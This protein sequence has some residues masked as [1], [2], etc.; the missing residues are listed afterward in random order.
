MAV[1]RV[2]TVPED[3]FGEPREHLRRTIQALNAL[4]NGQGNNHF[5]VT[6]RP[7]ETETTVPMRSATIGSTVQI[8]PMS[9]SAAIEVGF[10]GEAIQGAVVIHHGSDPGQ[11][12]VFGV[13]ISG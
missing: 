6:L 2:K 12:R 9:A 1:T 10:W 13:L 3:R 4:Q 7:D 11:D 5:E 8:T